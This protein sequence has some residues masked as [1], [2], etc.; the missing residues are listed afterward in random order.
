MS[1]I[2]PACRDLPTRNFAAGETILA[3]GRRP[4]C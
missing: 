1:S 2:L 3:E 4:T